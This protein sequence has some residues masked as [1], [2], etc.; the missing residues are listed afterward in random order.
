VSVLVK[1]ALAAWRVCRDDFELYRE[2]A[3][4]SAHEA[5]TG[6][7]LNRRGQQ[8]GID[9]WSLFIGNEARAY[10]Y[11]SEELTDWWAAHPRLTFARF[12]QQWSEQRDA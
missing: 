12:E 4:Q 1:E 11:A 3:Y 5:C 8:A 10:A 2:Y 7:L 9:P 6:K